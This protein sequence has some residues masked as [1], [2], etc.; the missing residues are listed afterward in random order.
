[1]K[2]LIEYLHVEAISRS[3]SEVGIARPHRGDL[4]RGLPYARRKRA[5]AGTRAEHA[6]RDLLIEES[7]PET[8]PSA[9]NP[10][11]DSVALIAGARRRRRASAWWLSRYAVSVPALTSA[12][13][14]IRLL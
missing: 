11:L 1:V 12:A 10:G 3:S 4:Q 8:L 2:L 6:A 7:T 13:S 5:A 14:A 9:N